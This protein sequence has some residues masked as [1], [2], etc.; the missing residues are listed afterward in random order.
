[1][2][3]CWNRFQIPPMTGFEKLLHLCRPISRPRKSA[4]NR[5]RY[6][7]FLF[8][9]LRHYILSI[10]GLG[11]AQIWPSRAAEITECTLNRPLLF[12]RTRL[13]DIR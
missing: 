3:N 11:R 13:A 7:F 10:S 1:M 5:R 4:M 9:P 12:A 6:Q 8:S 2:E